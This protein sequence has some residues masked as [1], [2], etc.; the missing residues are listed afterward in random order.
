MF[1]ISQFIRL[2]MNEILEFTVAVLKVCNVFNA[3]GLATTYLP[4]TMQHH[5]PHH[6]HGAAPPELWNIVFPREVREAL[7]LEVVMTFNYF[8]RVG[9]QI[10]AA[11]TLLIWQAQNGYVRLFSCHGKGMPDDDFIQGTFT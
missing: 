3:L 5:V 11:W 10:Y 6:A 4:C 7:Q 9:I 1:P 8:C 2:A